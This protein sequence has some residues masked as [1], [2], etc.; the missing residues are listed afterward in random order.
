MW[1]FFKFRFA[2]DRVA[3]DLKSDA[4]GRVAY[5]N[6]RTSSSSSCVYSQN[7]PSASTAAVSPSP[8][9]G[10]SARSSRRVWTHVVDASSSEFSVSI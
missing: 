10:Y 1:A 9:A 7:S 6:F 2:C 3:E 5:P 8:W 4:P